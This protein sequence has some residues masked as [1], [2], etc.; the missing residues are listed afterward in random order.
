MISIPI[1]IEECVVICFYTFSALLNGSSS[2][3]LDSESSTVSGDGHST[4]SQETAIIRDPKEEATKEASSK[5]HS[6]FV[7]EILSGE[8]SMGWIFCQKKYDSGI[9][10]W[11]LKWN[12]R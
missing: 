5:R 3:S 1:S 8:T 12:K 9:C 11:I 6:R 2:V 10:L 4:V 7:I